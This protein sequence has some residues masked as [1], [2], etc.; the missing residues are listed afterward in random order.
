[1]SCGDPHETDCGEVLAEMWLFLDN[2]CNHER[3]E[4]LKRHLEE[5]GA[6]LEE[7]GL[8]EHLKA[9]LARKCGGDHAP[10]EFKQRLRQSIQEIM[11]RQAVL[12]AEVT[13][14]QDEDGTIVE[15]RTAV[16]TRTW[17]SRERRPPPH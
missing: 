4:L 1:M 14:E 11:V 13:V 8:E 17:T 5:C 9:L 10:D 6:C 7:Y 12:G 15:V 16:E 2:E 3:R